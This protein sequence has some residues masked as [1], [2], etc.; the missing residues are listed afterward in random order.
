MALTGMIALYYLLKNLL[1]LGTEYLR[2][3]IVG[4]SIVALKNTMMRGY[5]ELPYTFHARRNSADLIW[6]VNSGVEA[7]CQEAMSGAVAVASEILT[8]ASITV[9]LLITAP[10]ATLIA[11]TLLV[12]IVALLLRLMHNMA[13]RF[14][15]DRDRVN[16]SILRTL[17]EAFGGVKEIKTLGREAFFYRGLDEKLRQIL[18]LGYVAK[19]MEG[20]APVVTETVFVGGALAV[21]ALLAGSGATR[22]EGLP[23]LALFSYAAFRVVPSANRIAWRMNQI[24]G[25][26]YAAN[27]VY[28]DYLL[29]RRT[30]SDKAANGVAGSFEREVEFDEVCFA[31][32]GTGSAVLRDVSMTIRRGESIGVVG[33][34]GAGKSTLADLVSGLLEPTSGRVLVD[35]HDLRGLLPW[36][37][38][39]IGYVPQSIFLT[40]DTIKRN[41]ALGITDAEIDESRI[42][43]TLKMVHLDQFVAGLPQG[44]ETFVG[45]RG[46][47]LSGGEKQRLGIA[48]A[49]Y[50]D[51]D[52]LIFDEA[53]SALDQ[54][55][56]ADVGQAI[57]SLHGKKTLLV[58]AHRLT[59]VRH[60]DRL[61]FISKG[62]ISAS[63]TYDELIE[64][65]AEFRRMAMAAERP[66]RSRAS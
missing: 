17:S 58:I 16:K 47:R 9:V 1:V 33:A 42:V 60:C 4:E 25:A 57:E 43:E 21:I 24:R 8:A 13:V 18:K 56:E 22:S 3:K 39:R 40:D 48:R 19:S 27:T 36:W 11:G 41:I 15:R 50:H 23:L 14:G 66:R 20:S 30:R 35:G 54:A 63:G 44:L 31:Y 59:T 34:T 32:P 5:V 28:D 64:N 12:A 65:V 29:I 55:T 46:V 52:L 38:R 51:P 2:H 61:I 6:S 10:K 26:S 45:E 37:K 53:T 7:V 49:L 62:R